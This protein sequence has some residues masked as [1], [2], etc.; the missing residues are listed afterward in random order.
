[1]NCKIFLIAGLFI[2]PTVYTMEKPKPWE[3]KTKVKIDIREA[4]LPILLTKMRAIFGVVFET[5]TYRLAPPIL[6]TYQANTTKAEAWNF[7][8]NFLNTNGRLVK[9]S[10]KNPGIFY[11]TDK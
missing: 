10:K 11:I 9:H 2:A 1:V 8:V 5:M 6:L 3:D 4:N 7:L